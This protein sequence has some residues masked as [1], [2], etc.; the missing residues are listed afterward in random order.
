MAPAVPGSSA[1]DGIV[2]LFKLIPLL[3]IIL[4]IKNCDIS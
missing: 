3:A 4:S 2:R 1:E